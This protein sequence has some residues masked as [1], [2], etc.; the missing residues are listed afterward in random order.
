MIVTNTYYSELTIDNVLIQSRKFI[1]GNL[2]SGTVEVIEIIGRKEGI[3]DG[4]EGN[5]AQGMLYKTDEQAMEH[6]KENK[7]PKFKEVA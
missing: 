6:W 3:L 7:L 1:K 4:K 2:T 5:W